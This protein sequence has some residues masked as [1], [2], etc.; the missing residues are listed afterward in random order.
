MRVCPLREGGG[1]C[2]LSGGGGVCRQ[3]GSAS[4][5]SAVETH[6]TG[7][8]SCI[9]FSSVTPSTMTSWPSS[10]MNDRRLQMYWKSSKTSYFSTLT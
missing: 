4:V 2:P 5:Q 1:V 3:R 10:I 8:Q 9:I 7:M 6:P